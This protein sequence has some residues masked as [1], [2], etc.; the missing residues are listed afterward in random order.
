MHCNDIFFH[1]E[2]SENFLIISLMFYHQVFSKGTMEAFL[3]RTVFPKL[4]H[5]MSEFNINPHQQLLG[6]KILVYGT[7]YNA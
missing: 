3:L 5:C 2:T 1:F 4:E 7:I 6:M